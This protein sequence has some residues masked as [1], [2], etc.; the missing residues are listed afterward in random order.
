MNEK[1][2][3]AARKKFTRNVARQ[4]STSVSRLV[5]FE[6][7][8]KDAGGDACDAESGDYAR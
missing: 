8:G 5:N 4:Y 2:L 1:F 3:P 7:C 6:R